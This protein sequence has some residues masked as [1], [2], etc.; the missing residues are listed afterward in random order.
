MLGSPARR[1]PDAEN[2]I[3]DLGEEGG[4]DGGVDPSDAS[5]SLTEKTKLEQKQM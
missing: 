1:A 3:S 2:K 5:F 4:G